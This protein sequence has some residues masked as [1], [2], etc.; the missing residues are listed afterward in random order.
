MLSGFIVKK[1]SMENMFLSDG[2]LVAVTRCLALPLKVTQI[3]TTQ[4]DGYESVQIAYGKRKKLDM[5]TSAKL[6]KLSIDFFPKGFMEFKALSGTPPVGSDILVEKVLT[7]DAIVDV[8]GISKGRGYAGVIKRYGFHRQPVSGGQS[9]R[10]RA[11]GAIGAQT[12]GKV[13]RGKKMPG[14]MG[15]VSKTI[16][17][18]RI[19]KIIPESNQ[20]L[21]S[22]G[23]PGARNSWLIITPK[24]SH[25]N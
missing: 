25:E 16:V 8:T 13:I 1:I 9:D 21:V 6:K 7:E 17:N 14:H 12:P 3:K 4:K 23:L 11:P 20:I 24:K 19:L 18:L 2:R 10:V 22:G 15:V 5:P